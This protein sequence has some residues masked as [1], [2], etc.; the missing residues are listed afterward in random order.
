MVLITLSS[1]ELRDPAKFTNTFS[2]G[3]V[4]KPNSY[5]C[6]ISGSVVEDLTN[7][8][9]TIAAGAVMSVRYDA[10]NCFTATLN[11]AETNYKLAAFVTH[12][13]SLFTGKNY[14]GRRFNA[15]LQSQGGD[16]VI[17]FQLYKFI[18]A[19]K[20][21]LKLIILTALVITSFFFIVF[22]V[23]EFLAPFTYLA[24]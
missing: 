21:Y 6:L 8:S 7:A 18:I 13:N 19:N 16:L 22:K 3:L 1:N 10:Y 17:A 15:E 9:I 5:I 4:I 12:L 14:L 20:D 23:F 11:A 2:E 24:L